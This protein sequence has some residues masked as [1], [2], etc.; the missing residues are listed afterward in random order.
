[1]SVFSSLFRNHFLLI[2]TSKRIL[3][4]D[5]CKSLQRV[6]ST[7][8]QQ[9]QWWRNEEEKAVEQNV[10]KWSEISKPIWPWKENEGR[11]IEF[12][13]HETESIGGWLWK[14]RKR[15][16]W[17]KKKGNWNGCKKAQNLFVWRGKQEGE[18]DYCFAKW[19]WGQ[20]CL[21]QKS[22]MLSISNGHFQ[23]K[24]KNLYN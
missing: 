15:R 18:R 10:T 24:K 16:R 7:N 8:V 22:I 9:L 4:N 21:N 11:R 19:L 6:L 13:E 12:D 3:R 14:R 2:I 23:L 5:T 20:K 17:M 1:M